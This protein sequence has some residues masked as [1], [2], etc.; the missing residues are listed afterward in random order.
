MSSKLRL[1][2][3]AASVILPVTLPGAASAAGYF[4]QPDAPLVAPNAYST[5]SAQA[6]TARDQASG[7][8]AAAGDPLVAP[9]EYNTGSASAT[10]ARQRA[11][12]YFAEAG[13]PLVSATTTVH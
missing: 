6:T 10:L 9:T 13:A 12:G 3:L 5:G 7:Y 1:L 2:A 8:F 11:S 4:D